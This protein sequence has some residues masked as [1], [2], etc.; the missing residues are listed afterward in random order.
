MTLSSLIVAVWAL[1]AAVFPNP[2][3]AI[4]LGV[5][6]VLLLAFATLSFAGSNSTDQR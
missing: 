5:L 1:T 4:L 6:S 3:L 2:L